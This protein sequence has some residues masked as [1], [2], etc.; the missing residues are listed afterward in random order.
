M[1]RPR[2]ARRLRSS[3]PSPLSLPRY[4]CTTSPEPGVSRQWALSGASLRAA[5][6][7]AAGEKVAPVLGGKEFKPGH[8]ERFRIALATLPP[9]PKIAH[10]TWK[11][12]FELGDWNKSKMIA[13]GW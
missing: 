1:Y 5:K 10:F 4:S 11:E 7:Q 3:A 2:P 9:I 6:A 8:L 12:T 13:N